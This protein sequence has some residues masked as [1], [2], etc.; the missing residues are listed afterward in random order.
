MNAALLL[1]AVMLP[2]AVAASCIAPASRRLALALAPWAAAPALLL[3]LVSPAG[4]LVDLPWFQLGMQLG[5]HPLTRLFLLFT[6]ILW[7]ASALYARGYLGE[8]PRRVRFTFF[9]MLTLAGNIGLIVALDLASFYFFFALMTFAA[10][11]LVIHAGSAEA[12]RAGRVYIALAVIG[13]GLL[14]AGLLAAAHVSGSLL[15]A[16]L[17][18]AVALSGWRDVI[19]V[20]LLT[21]FGVKAGL[22]GL[23][24]WLPL[25]HPI[26][27]TPA[28]AVLSGAMI[29]AGLLGWLLFLPLDVALP[30]WGVAFA[31]LGL[32]AALAGAIVGVLQTEAKAMLAYSSISQMGLMLVAVALGF[33]PTTEPGAIDIAAFYAAH[34]GLAKAALFL[35]VGVIGATAGTRERRAILLLL[36]LPAVAL[37]G[38]PWTSGA[39]AKAL[40]EAQL[41][42]AHGLAW[43]KP[44][45][46]AAAVG[47]GAL[48][49]RLLLTLAASAP[50]SGHR[51]GLPAVASWLALTV[52]SAIGAWWLAMPWV[53]ALP[54]LASEPIDALIPLVLA[55]LGSVLALKLHRA[56]WRAWQVAPGDVIALFDLAPLQRTLAV[57]V[58]RVGDA[59]A[60]VWL[61]V[62]RAERRARRRL[63][64][65][66][67]REEFA[68]PMVAGGL[69]LLFVT[70]L[71]ILLL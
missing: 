28:S 18:A 59:A 69:V 22:L 29:K 54:A 40:V 23:H 66:V 58:R 51:L 13:E 21:G 25:A 46:S 67:G 33:G 6:S 38:A 20:L 27:P 8:D 39:V 30:H 62:T 16:D 14:L 17:P 43:V 68:F 1:M 9:F 71:V 56:G 45:L 55:A 4:V 49:I 31:A 61:R 44:W 34:H 64:V 53:F 70:T 26:A 36:A 42:S 47:T 2:L 7:L 63:L 50:D 32:A 12:Y 3:A 35:G 48:M 37:V 5:L 19:I 15:I 41:H 65:E 24:M 11:G 10:Y 57:T 52:A 60:A